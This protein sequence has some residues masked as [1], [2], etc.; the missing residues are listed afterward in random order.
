M[1]NSSE[2]RTEQS[3]NMKSTNIFS[4]NSVNSQLN[5][6]IID[7]NDLHIGDTIGIGGFG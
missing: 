3:G 6:P 5:I 7:F 1:A 4:T 2:I